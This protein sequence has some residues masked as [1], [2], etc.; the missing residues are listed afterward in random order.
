MPSPCGMVC[1]SYFEDQTAQGLN[2][3][4]FFAGWINLSGI[5]NFFLP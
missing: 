5:L 1:G 4:S 3:C 2:L